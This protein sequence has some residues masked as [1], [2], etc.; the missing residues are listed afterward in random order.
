MEICDLKRRFILAAL[1]RLPSTLP[2][3]V[4]FNFPFGLVFKST[5]PY[6]WPRLTLCAAWEWARSNSSAGLSALGF[7]FKP[8]FESY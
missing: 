1:Y 7:R 2:L 3:Q 8:E 5:N 4:I 6:G